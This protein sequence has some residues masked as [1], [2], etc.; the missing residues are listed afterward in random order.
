MIRNQLTR[1]PGGALF[2]VLALLNI[3]SAQNV[4]VQGLI[5]ARSGPTLIVQTQES[6]NVSVLLTDN[7]EVSQIQGVFKARRKQMAM[8]ALIPGL[9]IQAEGSYNHERQLVAKSVKFKGDDLQQAQSI[10][11]GMHE[12]NEKTLQHA[13]ELERQEAAL[14]TQTEALKQQQSELSAQQQKIASNKAAIDAAISRFGQLDDY[15]IF[16][17]VSVYFAN[18]QV[19]V[20]AKYRPD[21]LRL[22]EK[23][24]TIQGF[25]IEVKGY[26]SS[27]GNEAL[28]QKLSED[29]AN[30]VVN[31]LLQQG[32]IPITNMLA[33]GA[34][35]ESE[36]VG[37]DKTAEGQAENRRVVVRVLQNKGI[38]GISSLSTSP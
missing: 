14:K 28:N 19:N 30:N 5:K 10:Q 35:G 32:H 12:A 33:P 4:K 29:R 17:E 9:A 31:L 6:P 2:I 34:M 22:A 27:A 13:K 26:A 3:A 25:M 7:T 21:L 38:A 36:Q 8:A 23:A 1:A 24:K 20:E 37:N 18:A 15:Y 16:D 11:A